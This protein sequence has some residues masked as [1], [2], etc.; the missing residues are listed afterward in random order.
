MNRITDPVITIMNNLIILL[1]IV[2]NSQRSLVRTKTKI[3][4]MFK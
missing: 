4:Y 2:N 1:Y 3:M